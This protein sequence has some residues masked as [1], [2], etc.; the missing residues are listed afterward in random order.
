MNGFKA[1]VSQNILHR[2][3]KPQNLLFSGK[4][5]KIGDFGFCKQLISQNSMTKT[6]I[7]SP[8]YMAPEVLLGKRI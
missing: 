5:I 6:M 1:L 2:D 7:G 4:T 8:I 3:I